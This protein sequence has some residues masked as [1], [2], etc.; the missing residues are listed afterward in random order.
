VGFYA[1]W[2][3]SSL[4]SRKRCVKILRIRSEPSLGFGNEIPVT[5]RREREREREREN[6][7]RKLVEVILRD[8]IQ[9]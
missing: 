2:N 1:A 4:K 9:I 6:F 5:I 3:P 7:L 8:W